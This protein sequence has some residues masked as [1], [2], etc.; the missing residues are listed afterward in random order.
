MA[1]YLAYHHTRLHAG[2]VGDR[3]GNDPFCWVSPFVWSHCHARPRPLSFGVKPRLPCVNGRDAMFF[4]GHHP[5]SKALVI[6][7]V[8]VLDR[9]MPIAEAEAQWHSSHPI[10]HYHFDQNREPTHKNS[11][12]TWIACPELSF[13][14]HPAMPIADWIEDYV[15]SARVTIAD[16]FGQRRRKS[17]RRLA[18]PQGLYDKVVAWTRRLGHARLKQIPF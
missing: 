14:A 3:Y 18:H 12:R 16:Y 5:A 8:L 9:M 1:A 13:V 10:R 2:V 11:D 4:A 15:S 7:S 17:A 6:D